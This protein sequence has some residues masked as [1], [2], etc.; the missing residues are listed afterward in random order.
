MI[1]PNVPNICKLID[2]NK[3]FGNTDGIQIK[4]SNLMVISH[5]AEEEA[6]SSVP[7]DS[8]LVH[9]SILQKRELSHQ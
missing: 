8:K 9:V 4:A 3:E 6:V 5:E 2:K 7:A 1:S